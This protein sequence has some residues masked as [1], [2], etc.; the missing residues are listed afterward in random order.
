MKICRG[1]IPVNATHSITGWD[2]KLESRSRLEVLPCR[3][4]VGIEFLKPSF[5]LFE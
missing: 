3:V 1:E 4:A 2:R 5:F